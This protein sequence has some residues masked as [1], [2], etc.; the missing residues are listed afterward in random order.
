MQYIYTEEEHKENVRKTN[1]VSL[2]AEEIK[3]L[4]NLKTN[5]EF[6]GYINNLIR[7]HLNKK[8]R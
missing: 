3:R 2:Y 1:L 5:K 4:A 7:E 6:Q 8:G